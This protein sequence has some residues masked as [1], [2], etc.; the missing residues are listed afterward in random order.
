[1]VACATSPAI[2]AAGTVRAA[3]TGSV[4]EPDRLVPQRA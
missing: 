1:M 2:R 4:L 3:L